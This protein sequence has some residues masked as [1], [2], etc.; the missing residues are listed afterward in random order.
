MSLKKHSSPHTAH[1]G[2]GHGKHA[3]EIANAESATRKIAASRVLAFTLYTHR[4]TAQ[5]TV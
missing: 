1:T 5:H 3:T 2:V 4:H